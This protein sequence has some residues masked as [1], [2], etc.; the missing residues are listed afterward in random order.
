MKVVINDCFGGFSLSMKA[1]G[2]LRD[3]GHPKAV[4]EF[5]ERTQG[6]MSP[7]SPGLFSGWLDP[8][9]FSGSS[10]LRDI[11]RA[12]PLLLECL[13]ELGAEANGEGA[14]LKIVEIPDG[15]E[16]EIEEY[17]GSEHIAEA[18]RTWR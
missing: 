7:R 18:H 6:G 8:N 14:K 2:W 10:W 16:Y 11:D 12:A 3:R 13:A 9:G 5:K 4:E 1:A 15:I 17:D